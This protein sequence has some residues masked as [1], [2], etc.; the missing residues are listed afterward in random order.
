MFTKAY[1][2]LAQLTSTKANNGA[3]TYVLW[4]LISIPLKLT[5]GCLQTKIIFF[6][7]LFLV[8]ECSVLFFKFRIF[9]KHSVTKIF[10]FL[11]LDFFTTAWHH[12]NVNKQYIYGFHAVTINCKPN[13]PGLHAE[14]SVTT[15]WYK[16]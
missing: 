9:W 11:S 5:S 16:L 12:S 1:N 8:L 6:D 15:K 2:V 13:L 10:F 14:N 7:L 3:Y 4:L